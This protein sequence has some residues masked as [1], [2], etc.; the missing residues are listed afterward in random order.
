LGILKN[1][2]TFSSASA[3]N[4]D[5]HR[6]VMLL[7]DPGAFTEKLDTQDWNRLIDLASKHSIAQVL[8]ICLKANPAIDVSPDAALRIREIYLYAAARNLKVY[9]KL[10]I[11]LKAFE[12]SGV[13]VVP[14]KGAW[15]TKR[16][17]ES[18]ALRQSVD[19][20]L[21]V[22][23]NQLEEARSVMRS[24]G[25]A[26]H[27]RENRP[28][29]LQDALGGETKM[30]QKDAP[31]VELHWKVFPGEWL[32]LT[33]RIDEDIVWQR[34]LPF[35]SEKM[36]QLSPEDAIIQLCV[37]HAVSHQ[38]SGPG[39]RTLLDLHYIREKL[40]IDWN[41]LAARALMWR[42]A[43]PTW[44]VL[45]M[46]ADLFG[47]PE[48]KLPLHSLEPSPLRQKILRYFV[49]HKTMADRVNHSNGLKRFIFLLALVDKPSAA[50]YL[51][52]RGLIPDR[53]WLILRYDIQDAP[54]WRIWFQYLKH[55]S[56]IA[57]K[58]DL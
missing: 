56:Y 3:D 4:R 2:L 16:V 49:T 39:L 35:Y 42:V 34:T 55:F 1:T 8:Q 22:Q 47:D 57:L 53:Q 38:M 50:C 31:M 27:S 33:G 7:R 23:R 28:Q 20:D 10:D 43:T 17:Y 41:V 36:R 45:K 15:L 40:P 13:V 12:A 30:S 44:I 54:A 37:H 32:R 9:H 52:W 58:R 5:L 51:L 29:T 26:A 48:K 6:L 46:F 25:Y 19:V 14:F 18:I 11:I 24:L 21:W